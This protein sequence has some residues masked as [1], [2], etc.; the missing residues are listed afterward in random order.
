[1]ATRE[2]PFAAL[3]ATIR[4]GGHL[5]GHRLH[6]FTFVAGAGQASLRDIQKHMVT[7]NCIVGDVLSDLLEWGVLECTGK[8]MSPDTGALVGVY[9]PTGRLPRIEGLVEYRDLF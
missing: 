3:V 9:R 6:L 8:A 4:D 5:K 1:M 7:R 2:D